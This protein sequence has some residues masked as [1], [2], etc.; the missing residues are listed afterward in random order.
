MENVELVVKIP[1]EEYDLIVNDE[2]CGLNVLTRA[3]ANGK[4]LSKGHGDLVDVKEVEEYLN[5][6]QLELDGW[7]DTDSAVEIAKAKLGLDT[8]TP[9]IEADK[10]DDNTR[11]YYAN[12]WN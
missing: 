10:K 8:I 4:T 5:N 9:I 1:K 12:E 2:A 11:P 3:I 7:G 6:I